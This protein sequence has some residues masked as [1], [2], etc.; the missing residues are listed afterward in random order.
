MKYLKTLIKQYFL[1]D[2]IKKWCKTRKNKQ[3]N[4]EILSGIKNTKYHRGKDFTKYER[5]TKNS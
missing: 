4:K 5:P 1:V 2:I 3:I